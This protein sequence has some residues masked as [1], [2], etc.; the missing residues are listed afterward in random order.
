MSGE[1]QAFFVEAQDGRKFKMVIR[2]D[3]RKLSVAKIR[4]YLKAYD[5]NGDWV[6]ACRG[7]PLPD[8]MLGEEFGLENNGLLQLCDPAGLAAAGPDKGPFALERPPTD[9]AATEEPC[10]S[11]APSARRSA[12]ARPSAPATVPEASGMPQGQPHA[13]RAPPE[14]GLRPS[15][16][17]LAPQLAQGDLGHGD[18][19]ARALQSAH[20]NLACL[21]EHLRVALSLDR[22]LTCVVCND[23]E[24]SILVTF[25]PPTR[26]LYVYS[27]V[28]TAIPEDRAVRTK[29]YE[30]LL[31]GSLLGR[32]VCGGGIGVSLRGG[33]VVLSTSILTA[34]C[35][36]ET[37]RE[38]IP[39]F[40]EALKRWRSLVGEL[41][42]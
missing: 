21:A 29:L 14:E 13:G 12:G 34:H 39:T 18:A 1:K 27:T 38:V 10:G 28:L 16:E 5:V 41:V 33:L 7:S 37:L 31:E 19:S 6:L 22:N 8:D 2:G 24:Y 15:S 26:R 9:G 42:G 40:V 32:E 36:R 25:D 23:E 17:A 4:R 11:S 30:V 3:L 20:D 35:D